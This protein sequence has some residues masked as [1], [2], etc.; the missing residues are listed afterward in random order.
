MTYEEAIEILT[1]AESNLRV[2]GDDLKIAK[3][4]ACDALKKQI[5]KKPKKGMPGDYFC[6]LCGRC[7]TGTGAY[8]WRCGQAVDWSNVW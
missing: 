5:P 6:G 1:R 2:S 7:V 8:C 4:M 3:K